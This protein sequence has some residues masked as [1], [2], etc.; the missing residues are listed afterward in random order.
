MKFKARLFIDTKPLIC[1]L[2]A[3]QQPIYDLS[4]RIIWSLYYYP[5]ST[6]DKTSFSHTE[7]FCEFSIFAFDLFQCA[8]SQ[9]PYS[10]E[11]LIWYVGFCY[12][13]DHDSLFYI[14]KFFNKAQV[15]RFLNIYQKSDFNFKN[16]FFVFIGFLII[17]VL[18]SWNWT[19][20]PSKR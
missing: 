15:N 6:V 7:F 3:L 20:F 1:I 5:I 13:K 18:E 9:V 8:S 19:N 14:R 12:G 17:C 11:G 4:Y 2:H 10:W 16:I